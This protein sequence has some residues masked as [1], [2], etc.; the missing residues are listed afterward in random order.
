MLNI[1][2]Y[3]ILQLLIVVFIYFGFEISKKY[4]PPKIKI[5]SILVLTFLTM[6]EVSLLILF[7]WENIMYLYVLKPFVF[8]HLIALPLA[9]VICLFILMRN[10]KFNFSYSFLISG[11]LLAAYILLMLKVPHGVQ[12]SQRFGYY[13]NLLNPLPPAF[14]YI[15]CNTIFMIM[16]ILQL[17]KPM[18]NNAGLYM[19]VFAALFSVG[20]TLLGLLGIEFLVHNIIGDFCWV[21]VLNYSLVRLKSK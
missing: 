18:V 15:A 21:A 13:I 1:Y 19:V 17:G 20:E 6:R 11:I 12:I 7:F 2:L 4:A 8:L 10:D 5:L 14:F 3:L 9:S 16:A